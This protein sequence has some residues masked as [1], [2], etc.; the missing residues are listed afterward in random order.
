MTA[1]APHCAPSDGTSPEACPAEALA[2]SALLHARAALA[3]WRGKPLPDTAPVPDLARISPQARWVANARCGLE[4]WIAN[5]GF[6]QAEAPAQPP[7]LTRPMMY[8]L[9]KAACGHCGADACID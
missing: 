8:R 7:S 6:G 9:D 3:R 5:G 2:A 4:D 1:K